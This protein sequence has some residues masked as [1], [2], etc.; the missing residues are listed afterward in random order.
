MKIYNIYCFV[1]VL[2]IRLN[3]TKEEAKGGLGK[4]D[5]SSVKAPC[6]PPLNLTTCVAL[7]YN[8]DIYHTTDGLCNN[9]NNPGWGSA[10]Q[11]YRRILLP[12]YDDGESYFVRI[13]TSKDEIL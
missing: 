8:T 6:I 13:C 2:T 3:L 7:N 12:A 9:I 1:F 4:I 5:K 10:G 11:P